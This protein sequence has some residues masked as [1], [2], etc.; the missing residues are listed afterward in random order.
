MISSG[1]S[2]DGYTSLWIYEKP[3]NCTLKS[4]GFHSTSVTSQLKGDC[5]DQCVLNVY[6]YKS[7]CINMY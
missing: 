6:K 2:G 4:G 3:L 1:L 5:I 7:I